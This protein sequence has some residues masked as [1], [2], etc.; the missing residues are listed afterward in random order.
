MRCFVA[1]WPDAPARVALASLSDELRQ[2]I[3]YQRATRADDLHLTLAFIG[4]LDDDV[5]FDLAG[6]ITKLR[7]EPIAWQLNTLGFFEEA[8]V[9]WAG[10]ALQTSPLLTRLATRVRALLDAAGVTY[11]RKP[12]APHITLLRGVKSFSTE[13]IDPICWRIESVALYR[14]AP[15]LDSSRSRYACVKR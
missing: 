3:E 8:G 14:S 7:F 10:A 2:R 9:L 12:L 6:A 13:K 11:D 5:A 1:A 4:N 15:A